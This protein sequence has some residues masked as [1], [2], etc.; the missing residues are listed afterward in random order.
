MN[1]VWGDARRGAW[2]SY[3]RRD[4]STDTTK[5]ADGVHVLCNDRLESTKFARGTRLHDRIAQQLAVSPRWDALVAALPAMLG[6]HTQVASPAD[7][8][9][10]PGAL[11]APLTANCIHTATYGTRCATLAAF[12]PGAVRTY[13]HADGPPCVTPFVDRRELLR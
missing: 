2:I 8:A 5:L 12:A 6:D 4:G 7:A 10:A 1:L 3:L 11:P 13:L 9:P